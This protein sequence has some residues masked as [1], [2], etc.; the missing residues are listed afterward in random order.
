MSD[1]CDYSKLL[2]TDY[3]QQVFRGVDRF[4][5]KPNVID[6]IKTICETMP[7]LDESS[8]ALKLTLVNFVDNSNVSIPIIFMDD[9]VFFEVNMLIQ[10][11]D[12]YEIT[13]LNAEMLEEINNGLAA[14][15]SITNF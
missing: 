15:S 12:N 7:S 6:G 9:S 4:F 13:K 11:R 3:S 5:S 2:D 8:Y 10:L 14:N 1:F